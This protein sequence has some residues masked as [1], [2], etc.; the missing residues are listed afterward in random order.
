MSP[1]ELA[2]EGVAGKAASEPAV[3]RWVA[4]NIDNPDPDPCEC[5]D[6][7]AWTLLRLCREDPKFTAWFTEKLWSKLIPSRSQL[8]TG[9]PKEF[10]GKVTL[11]LIERI[12]AMREEAVAPQRAA[13]VPS[14]FDE[15]E[16][17]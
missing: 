16:P 7:F 5:P 1:L 2:P 9:G 14:A 10:D 4:R 13:S 17:E 6:P 3:V 15:W 8:D 11:D 12:Q